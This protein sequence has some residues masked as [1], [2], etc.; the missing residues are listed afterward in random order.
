MH[1]SRPG[2][3]TGLALLGMMTLTTLVL[4]ADEPAADA[5]ADLKKMQGEWVSKDDSGESTWTFKDNHLSLKTPTRQY[6]I[7]LTLD[8]KAK[9]FPAL[10]MK[11]LDTSPNAAGFNA[12]AIY[13]FDGD[14]KLSICFSAESGVRP[15]E[16]KTEIGKSFSFDLARK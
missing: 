9:P 7:D 8:P 11:V 12:P 1:P 4:R 13:K 5:K 15:T 14:K 10:E 16:F 6:E 3:N 2:M